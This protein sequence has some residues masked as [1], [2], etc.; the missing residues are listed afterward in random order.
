MCK[1]CP[2]KDHCKAD[3]TICDKC[4]EEVDIFYPIN[5]WDCRIACYCLKCK[6]EYIDNENQQYWSLGKSL[7]GTDKIHCIKCKTELTYKN[8]SDSDEDRFSV[9]C[10][11]CKLEFTLYHGYPDSNEQDYLEEKEWKDFSERMQSWK[12]QGSDPRR[13]PED[14]EERQIRESLVARYGEY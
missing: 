4:K 10:P 14:P 8:L 2:Q 9:Y 3:K 5:V 1:I 13:K 12:E 11:E 7:V 6:Q